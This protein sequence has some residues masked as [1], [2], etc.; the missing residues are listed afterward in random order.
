MSE[1]E[2]R[3]PSID[4]ILEAAGVGEVPI[5][6]EEEAHLYNFISSLASALRIPVPD[7]IDLDWYEEDSRQWL[8]EQAK[9]IGAER[10]QK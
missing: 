4:E 1:Q 6:R 7:S 9:T 3:R 10:V 2:G 5:A 8:L